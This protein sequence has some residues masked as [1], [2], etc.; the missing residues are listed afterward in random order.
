M[1]ESR[2]SSTIPATVA[3]CPGRRGR[4]RRGCG[5]RRRFQRPLRRRRGE[6]LGAGL[7]GG[8]R[9]RFQ[10]PLRRRTVLGPSRWT[11]RSGHRRRFQRPLRPRRTRSPVGRGSSAAIVD[12]SSDRCD[13]P[14]STPT[15]TPGRRPSST[16]P[17]TVATGIW[18]A[19]PAWWNLRPSSTI[20]ATVAT[21]TPPLD[22]VE[23][24]LAAIVD[25]SSDRCDRSRIFPV[26]TR[27]NPARFER[28]HPAA[29]TSDRS[30]LPATRNTWQER[31]E[32]SPAPGYAHD[33]SHHSLMR[34]W[35]RLVSLLDRGA[36]NRIH[37]HT[38][39]P[40][41]G[42]P[43]CTTSSSASGG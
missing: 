24:L 3:T 1:R 22:P 19:S 30:V 18:L 15:S 40:G 6:P 5:H 39:S 41:G 16:I 8:H 20:P 36:N 42:S 28:W 10:R 43:Y 33:R 37:L 27:T 9:R 7:V 2:P 38:N 17:A 25:D 12:D 34:R 32:R 23:I 31:F 26:P 21:G 13:E 4:S 29:A 11:P 14:T 35:R